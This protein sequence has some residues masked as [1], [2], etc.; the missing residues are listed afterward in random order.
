MAESALVVLRREVSRGVPDEL[1]ASLLRAREGRLC[2][3]LAYACLTEGDRP[4]A[5][6]AIRRSILLSPSLLKNYAYIC[7]CLL[8]AP[9]RSSMFR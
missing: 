5:V 3:D 9:M 1:P 6:R 4:G 8:P 2:H 7:V